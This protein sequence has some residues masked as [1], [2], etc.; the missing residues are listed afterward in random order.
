MRAKFKEGDIVLY[1]LPKEGSFN[2]QELSTLFNR[3]KIEKCRVMIQ[4]VDNSNVPYLI[5]SLYGESALW[6][7]AHQVEPIPTKKVAEKI[8]KLFNLKLPV[9]E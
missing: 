1:N 6:V 5:K 8:N 2:T 4:E 9:Y 3:G 7:Y